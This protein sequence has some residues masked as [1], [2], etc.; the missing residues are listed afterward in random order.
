MVSVQT[1]LIH[2][3]S[4][5]LAV[6]QYMVDYG[7]TDGAYTATHSLSLYRYQS[8]GSI[9]FGAGTVFWA[10][11]L[12]SDHD[13]QSSG[14]ETDSNAVQTDGDPN[15][16]TTTPIDLNVQQATVNLFADMGIQPQS[17]QAGLV[18]A[19]KWTNLVAPTSTISAL[20]SVT[21]QQL[22]TITVTASDA[23]GGVV[24]G[25]EVSTDRGATWHPASGPTGSPGLLNGGLQ[26]QGF[27]TSCR[28]RSTTA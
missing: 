16:P 27:S 19:T 15:Q 14:P 25:V 3:S 22:V 17:L 9:V 23:G 18:A 24:A 8:S 13:L 7:L 1:G 21:Q 12:D 6:G 5:T 26:P 20:G 10:W 4:T 28:A 2:L 11:G